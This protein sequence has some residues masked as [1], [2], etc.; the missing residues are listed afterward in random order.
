[1]MADNPR[2]RTSRRAKQLLG[3]LALLAL[4]GCRSDGSKGSGSRDPLVYGPNRIPPQNVPLSD[5]SGVGVGAKGAK[6]D[7]LLERPVG[8]N[9]DRSGVGY[10]DDPA[11]FSGTHIPGPGTTPAAL[12]A[13][14]KDGDELKIDTPDNRVPLRPAGGIVPIDDTSG[15]A[16]NQTFQELEKYGVRQEDRSLTNEDGKYVFRASVTN[17]NGTKR[18]YTGVG[19]TSD[20]AVR[21]VLDQVVQDRR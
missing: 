21:Q 6:T 16:A 15:P 14:T 19:S 20:E 1:M 7:P 11:R 5:R 3:V 4:A 2:S 13:K 18:S 17:S 10:N 12:A 8:K 9:G